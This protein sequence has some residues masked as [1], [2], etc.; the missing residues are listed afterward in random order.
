MPDDRQVL[1]R[2]RFREAITTLRAGG[3]DLDPDVMRLQTKEGRRENGLRY[4]RQGVPCPFLDA[5]SCS[6]HPVRPIAC[7]E[8]LVTNNPVHCSQPTAETIEMVDMP[9][10]LSGPMYQQ[11]ESGARVIPLAMALEWTEGRTY[12]GPVAPGRTVLQQ[13]LQALSH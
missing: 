6:I 1:V 2:Q 5:E 8:Y 13:V 11:T 12:S 10:K 7:R 4:F 3:V 9:A